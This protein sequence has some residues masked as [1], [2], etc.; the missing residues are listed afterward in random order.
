MAQ[1]CD[2]IIV[3]GG[4]NGA[5]TCRDASMRGLNTL[6]LERGDFASGA[7]GHNGRMIHGGLRYLGNGDIG[8]VIESLRERATLLAIAPH[9]VCPSTLLIPVRDGARHPEWML[10]LGLMAL[11]AL[12]LWRFP[13]HRRLDR[14]AALARVPSL[15]PDGLSAGFVMPDA[16]A[17][18]AERL[19][20]E[21]LLAAVAAGAVIRNHAPVTRIEPIHGGQ[22]RVTWQ[23]ADG[24]KAATAP[25]VVNATGAWTDAFLSRAAGVNSALITRAKGSFI[26]F[27]PRD[28]TPREAVFVESPAD[29]RP[30]LVT[31]WQGNIL[32]GTTDVVI[33]GA[34]D[35]AATTEAEVDYLLAALDEAFVPGT[36]PRS[37][38]CFTYCGVRPLPT[39][40]GPSHRITRKHVIHRHPAPLKGL[41]SIYGGKLSTFRSLAED[42]TDAVFAL[43]GRTSPRSMTARTPLPGASGAVDAAEAFA[44]LAEVTRRRLQAVY[45]TRAG[46]V[47]AL[48]RGAPDL[49]VVVDTESGAIAA[50]FVHAVRVEFAQTL[51]DILL[52]RTLLAYRPG[53]GRSAIGTFRTVAAAH[54]GWSEARIEADIAAYEAHVAATSGTRFH[55]PPAARGPIRVGAA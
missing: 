15:R 5:A 12:A 42:A 11:D 39:A 22:L 6:L 20:I 8:L 9:L 29:G 51:S 34:A 41:I 19:T 25:V 33:E 32:V 18:C 53:R 31:P 4:V 54:L 46:Q 7:S 55:A 36:F 49:A 47:A 30:V 13:R 52:R 17:E 26:V 35:T 27:E 38:I 40:A 44:P 43:L 21:N 48:A 50:E 2:L 1:A 37:A 10:R 16:Y 14:R 23:E 3:G 24:E 28:G 45:G